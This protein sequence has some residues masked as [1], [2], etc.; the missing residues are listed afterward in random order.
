MKGKGSKKAQLQVVKFGDGPAVTLDAIGR[1][2]GQYQ[3]SP[4]MGG[5]GS[6]GIEWF[7][8]GNDADP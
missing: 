8:Q 1:L 3:G 5:P 6:E 2:V 4:A 7:P